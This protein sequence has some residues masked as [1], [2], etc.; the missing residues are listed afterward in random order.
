MSWI[1]FKN[2]TTDDYGLIVVSLGRRQRAEEQID[3]YEIPYRNDELIIHSQTYKPYIREIELASKEK[4]KFPLVNAWLNGRGKLKTSIDENGYFIASVI[5]GLP[6]EQMMNSVD[7]FQ[8]GFK[9]NPFFYLDS[10]DDSINITM[11]TTIYNPGTI[12]SDPYIKITGSGN[13]DL[14][15]NDTI[16][17]FTGID[18]YIEINSD[19]KTVYRDTLNQG[20][21]MYG[22]FPILEV[23]ENI[24][25]W[26]GTVTS[27]EIIPKWRE[28]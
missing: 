12:Y 2:N 14:I 4:A 26:T 25:A 18:G 1:E 11:Q 6:Y 7:S 5:S 15:I 28:L 22:N 27:V 17:S 20:S 24:I 23:G 21:K 3:S 10:G 19:L 8:V 9:V 13:V 16:Y